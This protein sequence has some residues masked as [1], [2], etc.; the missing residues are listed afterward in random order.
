LEILEPEIQFLG[1]QVERGEQTP[2]ILQTLSVLRHY[3]SIS[4][5]STGEFRQAY[6]QRLKVIEIQE[7]L[8]SLRPRNSA[9]LRFQMAHSYYWLASL[10]LKMLDDRGYETQP[11][12]LLLEQ[13]LAITG[14]LLKAKPDDVD[15]ADLE[16][17][18]RYEMGT[19]FQQ[20]RRYEE[21]CNTYDRVIRDSTTLAKHHRG[22]PLLA[23]Y[24][25][26]C[27]NHSAD[28]CELRGEY[29]TAKEC[30]RSAKAFVKDIYQDAW[31]Q[32]WTVR[33]VADL[34]AQSARFLA[35]REE[36]QELLDETR[37]CEDWFSGNRGYLLGEKEGCLQ[38]PEAFDYWVLAYR[39]LAA[40][41]LSDDVEVQRITHRMEYLAQI[42]RGQSIDLTSIRE[43]LAED[44]VATP[45][46]DADDRR[47]N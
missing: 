3:A 8:L 38:S 34:Y 20:V 13:G 23:A 36:F 9:R 10:S 25:M 18:I 2:R 16:N 40:Q 30:Y 21:A 5:S 32:R 37:E 14:E 26:R 33:D 17:A 12:D 19:Y 11:P 4:Y 43:C 42:V 24:A 31:D 7:R 27:Y 46:L 45:E 44:S 6:E 47:E 29:S 22:R 15:V 28:I 1:N 41:R 39:R 35:R